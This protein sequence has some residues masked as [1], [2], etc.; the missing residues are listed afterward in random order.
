MNKILLV[1]YDK[2]EDPKSWSMT[3]YS[4]LKGLTKINAW[5]IDTFCYRDT[6]FQPVIDLYFRV[7]NRFFFGD[8]IIGRPLGFQFYSRVINR[9]I[10]KAPNKPNVVLFLAAHCVN[11]KFDKDVK[12]AAYIDVDH[13][14]MFPFYRNKIGKRLYILIYNHYTKRSLKRMD[15]IFTLNEWSRVSIINR[16]DLDTNKVLNVGV[17]INLDFFHG[18]KD[19]NNELLLIV[20]RKGMEDRKG[21]SLLLASFRHLKKRRPNVRLA[22]VGTEPE[23]EDEG[24][25]YYYNYPREKTKELFRESCLFVM[26][27]KFEPNGTTYLEA[28]ANKT[29]IVGM[30][31]FA[32]PEFSGYGKWGFILEK[33]D[34]VELSEL[35]NVALENKA[36]LK[37]MG[38]EGQEFVAKRY[39]WNEVVNQMSDKL[40]SLISKH[41]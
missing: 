1:A 34:S 18:D 6:I 9:R 4:I 17:G 39:Q 2:V 19:Y 23:T 15:V 32:F 24:V 5:S 12:Y 22:I 7:Y 20:L 31:K 10:C 36:R 3:P 33:E 29:P 35:L 11:I 13:N 27:A 14:K 8:E 40:V 41:D 38:I 37:S 28:L 16:Y 25:D 26:P 30:N 21:L